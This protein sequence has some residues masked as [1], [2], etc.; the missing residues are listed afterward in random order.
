[1]DATGV[2]SPSRSLQLNDA[3]R[4]VTISGRRPVIFAESLA[5]QLATEA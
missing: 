3:Q 2:A 4:A 1:M 5:A